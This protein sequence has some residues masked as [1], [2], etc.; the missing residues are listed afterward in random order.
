[1]FT[2]KGIYENGEI[3][4]LEPIPFRKK[5]RLIITV[6]DDDMEEQREFPLDFFDDLIGIISEHT[7]ASIKHDEYIYCKKSL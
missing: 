2:I 5:A 7:D 1:M 3:K 4:L 6:L